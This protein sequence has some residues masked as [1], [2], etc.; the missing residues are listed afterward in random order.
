MTAIKT[1][2][3]EDRTCTHICI[4]GQWHRV[5]VSGPM[6]NEVST[7][8]VALIRCVKVSRILPA[9]KRKGGG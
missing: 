2:G 5:Q 8:L 6:S 4:D 3:R 1:T 9:P 7:A